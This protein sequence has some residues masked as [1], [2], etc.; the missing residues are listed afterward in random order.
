MTAV[1][2]RSEQVELILHVQLELLLN[3]IS[4]GIVTMILEPV[5]NVLTD[6][7]VII[8][9]ETIPIEVFDIEADALLIVETEEAIEIVRVS[10]WK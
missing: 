5:T 6:T 3:D 7:K 9:L 2:L 8:M 1:V 10:I 4:V